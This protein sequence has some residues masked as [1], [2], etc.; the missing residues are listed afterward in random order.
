MQIPLDYYRIL[1]IPLQAESDL[2]VSAYEDRITQIPHGE[3]SEY[4]IKSRQN[5]I[6]HAYNILKN[7][8]SRQDYDDKV[9]PTTTESLWDSDSEV[10]ISE[11]VS[12]LDG[13]TI[14]PT[15]DVEKD[16][17][18]G[19]L[20]MLQE[21]G[22]YEL[23]STLAQ[24]Y[25]EGKEKLT[26][27]TQQTEVLPKIWQDLIL[28]VVN[29][30][31]ELA[32]EKWQQQEYDDAD[33]YLVKAYSLL[34]EEDCLPSLRREIN[35]NR[36]KLRP[37]LILQLLTQDTSEFQHRRR[38]LDLL[39]QM[40]DARGG[41]EGKN[42]DQSGLNTDDFLRFIQQIRSYLS[43]REQQEFFATEAQRPSNIAK[44]LS[45]NALMVMG[46]TERKPEYILE[47]KKLLIQLNHHQDVCIEQ[48]ICAFLL[49]EIAQA[50][51]FVKQSREAE[52][53]NFVL[54][55]S[56]NS[57]DLVPGLLLYTEKWFQEE[58]SEQFKNLD[59]ESFSVQLY[60][61]DERVQ[62]YLEKIA[63]P[64][65]D[66]DGDDITLKKIA[67]QALPDSLD[68]IPVNVEYPSALRET[69]N[70]VEE[71]TIPTNDDSELVNFNSFLSENL[72][73]EKTIIP[74]VV[75][76]DDDEIEVEDKKEKSGLIVNVSL[77]ILVLIIL[78]VL[79][80]VIL[81]NFASLV[82]IGRRDNNLELSLT[83]PL[84]QLP[85]EI[86]AE[87]A[88]GADNPLTA[89]G[90]VIIINQWL[91]AKSQAT[92]AEYNISA[93]ESILVDPLLSIWRNNIS[94]LK[95]QNA[96]RR[97]QHNVTIEGVNVNP[98]NLN[99]GNIIARVREKSEFFSNGRLDNIR[100]YD[101]EILV[102]YE[103][104]KVNN[105]WLIRNTEIVNN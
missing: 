35:D 87:E 21:L 22:E 1:G 76:N 31:W 63:P 43:A 27:I 36:C 92:G 71:T 88:I 15:I 4:G 30:N 12:L 74:D 60:F 28:T 9:F 98:Q 84:I 48:S 101:E 26:E 14:N 99:Q 44:Y 67:S 65:R 13:E 82:N 25:V 64:E 38:A 104:V 68:D 79:V 94:A 41:I 49:G 50:Q 20:M 33:I 73:A 46:F 51:V 91:E 56:A 17:F 37:Y 6:T 97:Y 45:I 39:S 47:A 62:N 90:A 100:S 70:P 86:V 61:E 78:A 69:E 57:L 72:E 8:K 83:E 95:N 80:N 85:E 11:A 58:L 81:N 89:E 93:L 5:L 29:S 40:L 10:S 34:E 55:K 18:I 54:E 24:P 19:A 52:K 16:E 103:L 96:Y 59:K 102:K 7:E 66:S 53:L 105:K 3:Y 2:I 77:S 75:N 32:R 23:V 42:D